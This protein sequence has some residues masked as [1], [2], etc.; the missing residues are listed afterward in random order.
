MKSMPI[1]ITKDEL[2]TLHYEKNVSARTIAK[3]LGIAAATLGRWAKELDFVFKSKQ[4]SCRDVLLNQ[5]NLSPS[6]E[7]SYVIGVYI[8]DGNVYFEEGAHYYVRLHCKDE[9]F[10][11]KFGSI[12]GS[13]IEKNVKH[14]IGTDG[15][16]IVR[17]HS[18]ILSQFLKFGGTTEF[19]KII[20]KYP[21]QFIA[22][23][24]ESEGHYGRGKH[25]RM[26]TVANTDINYLKMF[27]NACS[28]IGF[29]ASI[30]G[31]YYD[32]RGGRK[33]MLVSH[34][35]GGNT[36]VARFLDTVNPVIKG[37]DYYE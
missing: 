25:Q 9:A 23:F 36:E 5:V 17:A 16:Y 7:L 27:K 15:Y 22:G 1:S 8:G 13:L 10:A 20:K 26:I 32:K 14:K 2:H 4:D 31:P 18:K 11:S 3:E 19:E 28:T 35:L 34:I 6:G 37:V 33:P 21:L 12:V 29:K 30:N 24:Y